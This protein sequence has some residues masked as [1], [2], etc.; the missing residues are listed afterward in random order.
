MDSSLTIPDKVLTQTSFE[1]ETEKFNKFISD[2]ETKTNVE[3]TLD[4]LAHT[5]F[6]PWLNPQKAVNKMYFAQKGGIDLSIQFLQEEFP[7]DVRSLAGVLLWNFA[8]TPPM[9]QILWEKKAVDAVLPF[10]KSSR[11]T[12]QQ[13]GVGLLNCF[14]EFDKN[15]YITTKHTKNLTEDLVS[16]AKN[17]KWGKPEAL[18]KNANILGCLSMLCIHESTAHELIKCG[19]PV[20][21][22]RDHYEAHLAY[23]SCIGL[24]HLLMNS[25]FQLKKTQKKDFV[26]TINLF[27]KTMTPR[28]LRD[29]ESK[30]GFVW[31]SLVPFYSLTETDDINVLLFGLLCLANQSFSD[32]NR[33]L[34]QQENL[35]EK[36][37][38][39]QW[40]PDTRVRK[41]MDVFLANIGEH[42][43]PSLVRIC[44]FNIIHKYRK[45]IPKMKKIQS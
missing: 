42:P 35:M 33:D 38:C 30:I 43:V 32:Y 19:G 1:P 37:V 36:I 24:A 44:E 29:T 14:L 28:G 39:I 45:L 31:T 16:I 17:A 3:E 7:E 23:Y 20:F 4:K 12:L 13:V 5:E 27:L 10:L 18:T 8:E 26:R 11:D 25:H 2:L 9:M 41:Y 6:I 40:H 22:L 21:L 34:L 15:A